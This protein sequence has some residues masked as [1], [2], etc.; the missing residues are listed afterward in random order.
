MAQVDLGTGSGYT[1]R[2]G[3]IGEKNKL[4]LSYCGILS[5]KLYPGSILW[6]K[7]ILLTQILL[8]NKLYHTFEFKR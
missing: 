6:P 3:R 8:Y 7:E 5:I 1:S 2:T 4:F